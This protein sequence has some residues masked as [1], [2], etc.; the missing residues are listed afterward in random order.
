[1]LP[2]YDDIY[3][4]LRPR[5]GLPPFLRHYATPMLLPPRRR[6]ARLFLLL[7][8]LHFRFLHFSCLLIFFINV[9][10]RFID[11]PMLL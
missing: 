3:I 7:F 11:T 4:T 10:L 9:T 6:H 2:L 8:S 1:M 5:R